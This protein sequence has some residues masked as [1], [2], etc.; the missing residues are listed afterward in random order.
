MKYIWQN[1]NWPE[2]TWDAAALLPFLGKARLEQGRLLGGVKRLGFG[3][4]SEAQADILA[5]EVIKTA[6]IEGENLDPQMVRSSVARHLGLK[7]A[8]LTA[9]TRSIDGLVEVILDAVQNKDKSLSASR[10][11]AWHAALFPTGYSGLHKIRA[12]EWRGHEP[13]R[14]VSGPIG[15]E[16]VHFEAPPGKAVAAEMKSL[17]KWWQES[18]KNTDGILRAGIAHFYFVTVHP[19]EDGNGRIARA[20]TEM[21]LA[22]DEKLDVRYYSFSSQIMEERKGYYGILEKCSKSSTTNITAWLAWFLQC[23]ERAV[24]RSAKLL[25]RV[26]L[27]ANFWQEHAADTLN[28]RQK[29]AVNRMLDAGPGGFE[30]G[31]TTRKYA[32]MNK[33][34][35][36]TAFREISDMAAKK[37]LQQQEGRGRSVSYDLVW[38]AGGF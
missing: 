20:L 8:G 15:R 22:Q 14:V 6:A 32:G 38:P 13:M 12:G 21:A 27:K 18:R 9:T 30:G 16:R 37:V 5:E 29:K 17:L 33:V 1:R 19:F 34:S 31:L 3:A 10:L 24:Q 23:Y 11:K 36:A 25:E 4:N 2:L 35:R 26:L 7:T 28:G